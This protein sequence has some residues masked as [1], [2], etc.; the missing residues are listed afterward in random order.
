MKYVFNSR[1]PV[2]ADGVIFTGTNSRG[3]VV[4]G[5]LKISNA[6]YSYTYR[7]GMWYDGNFPCGDCRVPVLDIEDLVVVKQER[8]NSILQPAPVE[9]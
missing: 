7:N 9:E 4:N 1:I 5:E 3:E 6:D 8:F 2:L